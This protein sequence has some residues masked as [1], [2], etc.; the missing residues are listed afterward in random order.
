MHIHPV[1]H[2]HL[3]KPY[4]DGEATMPERVPIHPRPTPAVQQEGEE[5]EWEVESVLDQRL[6]GRQLQYLVKWKGYPLEEASWEPASH[7][8]NSQ[9]AV[10]DFEARLQQRSPRRSTRE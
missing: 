4:L 5:P 9:K 8:A 2:I 10:R 1:F 3:L 7:L 6:R